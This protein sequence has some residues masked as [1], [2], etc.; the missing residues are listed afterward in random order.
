MSSALR[1]VPSRTQALPCRHSDPIDR[2]DHE[3]P[4][5]RHAVSDGARKRDRC[6]DLRILDQAEQLRRQ[7][8]PRA[9]VQAGPADALSGDRGPRGQDPGASA[10]AAKAAPSPG[11][12]PRLARSRHARRAR[13]FCAHTLTS[14]GQPS[15]ALNRRY[16]RLTSATIMFLWSERIDR[17]LKDDESLCAA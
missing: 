2:V 17:Q 5:L 1:I 12:R 15:A 11:T 6:G 8:E 7:G 13:P 9:R 16:G 3:H 10:T 14:A 4:L